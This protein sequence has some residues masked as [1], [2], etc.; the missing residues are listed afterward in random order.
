M[1]TIAVFFGG[2]SNEHEI[3]VITGMYCANLLR[4]AGY[5]VL[6]VYLPV[7]GGMRLCAGVR[8]VDDFKE[9]PS[10]AAMPKEFREVLLDG[11]ALVDVKRPKRR[12]TPDCALN[13]CH[14]GAGEGGILSAL[15]E[16]SGIPSAS[17]GV[18]E[19]ALFLDKILA[20]TFLI[21]LGLPVV[22]SIAL[23]ES[24]YRARG[25]AETAEARAEAFGFPV[26]VK[27]ARLGSSI[28]IAVA[29]D[30]PG[31]R[32]ALQT[33]FRLDDA[34]LV[35]RYLDG[36]RDLN[37]AAYRCDGKIV[38]SS[39]E[40]VFSSGDILTFRE[41]YE[42]EGTRRSKIPAE[43]PDR[44]RAEIARCMTAV[45]E[46]FGTV[47]V[48]RGDFLL[49]GEELYFNE[50]NTVPGSLAAYLF[51]ESLHSARDLLVR[52]VEEGMARRQTGKGIIRSGIL[53]SKVFS[54][55]KRIK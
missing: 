55:S 9:L 37:C 25:G 39:V 13:C 10:A 40:E 17:P 33:A 26:I 4:G 14:G 2:R 46:A 21:G 38:L 18:A 6:P 31:F 49:V 27:P 24:E 34:V 41:K 28:G 54:G 15:L 36:K 32:R 5:N 48:I 23:R 53:S 47:G 50:L 51:G 42:G 1:K 3:S 8:S 22:E 19:S 43:I 11:G 16:W 30:M 29:E 12:Q 7:T 20:K 35:E 45:M 52:L 44:T